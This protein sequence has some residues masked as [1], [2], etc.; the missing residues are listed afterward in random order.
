M[1][2]DTLFLQFFTRRVQAKREDP[3]I[4]QSAS[5][6]DC[7]IKSGDDAVQE[8]HRTIHDAALELTRYQRAGV[9]CIDPEPAR[10]VFINSKPHCEVRRRGSEPVKRHSC[11]L[12]LER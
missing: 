12:R 5:K 8:H 3:G 10:A 7:R 11:M 4:H 9:F 6:M 2:F 1:H